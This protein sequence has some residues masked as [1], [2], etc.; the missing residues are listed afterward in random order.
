MDEKLDFY[1]WFQESSL[2]N[3]AKSVSKWHQS[4]PL[5]IFSSFVVITLSLSQFL[6]IGHRHSITQHV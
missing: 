3:L 2:D 6:N 5:L 4:E 1:R